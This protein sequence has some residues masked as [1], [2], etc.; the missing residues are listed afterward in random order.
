VNTSISRLAYLISPEVYYWET[1][2]EQARIELED[3]KAA[4]EKSPN[5]TDLQAALEEKEAYLDWPTPSRHG[6]KRTTKNILTLPPMQISRRRAPHCRR[7]RLL[8]WRHNT[9]T[10]R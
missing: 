10:R 5:D 8:C 7:Q 9:S 4:L 2:V 1:E 3:A 6:I